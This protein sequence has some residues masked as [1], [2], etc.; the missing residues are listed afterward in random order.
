MGK[1]RRMERNYQV[2]EEVV[3]EQE[4]APKKGSKLGKAL[5][6]G[7]LL[8]TVGV[9]GT[10]VGLNINNNTPHF[11]VTTGQIL[12]AKAD[13]TTLDEIIEMKDY[14]AVT[15]LDEVVEIV[16]LSER[17]H[18]LDLENV[19]EGLN[20]YEMPQTYDIDEVN[21]LID[22][23][24][25]YLENEKVENGVLCREDREFTQ[26]ALI[27]E[28]YERSVNNSLNNDIYYELSNYGILCVKS[29]VLDACFF[30]PEEVD[31]MRI[32]SGRNAYIIAFNDTQTGKCYNVTAYQGTEFSTA[33]YVHETIDAIYDWQTKANATNAEPTISY[34]GERNSDIIEG[35]NM[36]R[37]LTIMDCQITN[38]GQIKVTT[39]MSEVR[40]Y[41]K[42]IG[43]K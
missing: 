36:L 9:G 33:G 1:E 12:E 11:N 42:T 5:T 28:A 4:K 30:A 32:G 3:E 6:A 26:L 7:I 8:V 17:L 39:P 22:R 18:D 43:T 19:T 34:D 31:N 20:K 23:Y 41:A 10:L 29:K 24:N 16:E 40:D 21:G 27:L 14:T 35:V 37:A 25:A 2:E 13:T 38:N 15:D